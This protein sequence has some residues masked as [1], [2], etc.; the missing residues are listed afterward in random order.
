MDTG[1][2]G[3]AEGSN[4]PH[5]YGGLR[6]DMQMVSESTS[7]VSTTL[8]V[9]DMI[10]SAIYDTALLPASITKAIAK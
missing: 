2:L 9:I 4:G 6:G 3:Q 7:A 10:P 1:N 5:I 8:L